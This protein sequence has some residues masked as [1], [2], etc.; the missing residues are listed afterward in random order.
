L[1]TVIGNNSVIHTVWSDPNSNS[2][3][4]IFVPIYLF[5]EKLDQKVEL[6]VNQQLI[7]E[8]KK[9]LID[10][11]INREIYTGMLKSSY[12]VLELID[13]ARKSLNFW[14][15]AKFDHWDT[16]W[17]SKNPGICDCNQQ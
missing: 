16:E 17:P 13:F 11:K 12:T 10:V 1:Y 15:V 6:I 7:K 2:I 3:R 9:I 8:I 4:R 14:N 5:I